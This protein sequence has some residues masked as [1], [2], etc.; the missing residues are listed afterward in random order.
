M[1]IIGK[2]LLV[3][4]LT[5]E[6]IENPSELNLVTPNRFVF[7]AGQPEEVKL[8]YEEAT[9]VKMIDRE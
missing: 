5:R 6:Q 1:P 4:G 3:N 7:Q 8:A 9:G 2:D